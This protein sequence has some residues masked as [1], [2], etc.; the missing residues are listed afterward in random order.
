LTACGAKTPTRLQ[1][2]ESKML[3]L[4]NADFFY[5]M[6]SDPR[7]ASP[8]SR[9]QISN[10][11]D[12]ESVM[13]GQTY[14][15]K[16]GLYLDGKTIAKAVDSYNG[17]IADIGNPRRAIGEDGMPVV[18]IEQKA[19]EVIVNMP[20]EGDVHNGSV[21]MIVDRNFHVTSITTNV[22]LTVSESLQKAGVNTA[23]G[24]GTVFV[25]LIVISF[26]ISAMS[27]IPKL[28]EPSEKKKSEETEKAVDKTI[29]NIVE[30]EESEE[31]TDDTELAAVIAAAVAAFEGS[32]SSDGFVVRSIR[33]IR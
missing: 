21:E 22:D 23:I 26:I 4:Q 2:V 11:T 30:R 25:M 15:Q 7:M 14:L 27:V 10:F 3:I 19:D 9:E 16:T 29:A 12:D 8:E 13:I 1:S 6:V 24:M 20:L 31:E 17:S 18:N 32:S 5:D 28:M 33:R